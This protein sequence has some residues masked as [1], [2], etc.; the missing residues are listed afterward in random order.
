MAYVYILYSKSLDK[1]YIG[2]CNEINFRM[3]QHLSKSLDASFT[4]RA[5]DWQ[6]TFLADGLE[7]GQV[8]RIEKHIKRMK[9]QKNIEDL[10][11]Y[12]EILD[13]LKLKYL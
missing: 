7:Y 12:P 11:K 4:K 1:Y 8:R 6:L 5:N 2:S 13:K 10:K 3:E 9:S